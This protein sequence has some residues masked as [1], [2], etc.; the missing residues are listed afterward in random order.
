M[1]VGL[2]CTKSTWTP[3]LLK[4]LAASREVVIFDNRG[5]G[6]SSDKEGLD[7]L[8]IESMA[9]ST[10]DLIDALDI[11][12]PDVLGWS[13]V[14]AVTPGHSVS[15]LSCRITYL[16]IQRLLSTLKWRH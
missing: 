4:S 11:K 10:L 7:K 13:M 8:S 3:D 9:S 15:D 5:S 12:Q 14:R 16:P 6:R 1:I 2:G